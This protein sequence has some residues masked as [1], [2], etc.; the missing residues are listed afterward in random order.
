MNIA[1]ILTYTYFVTA[2]IA[3]IFLY[4]E[5]KHPTVRLG[6]YRMRIYHV[7]TLFIVGAI[8]LLANMISGY[9]EILGLILLI[10]AFATP[11]FLFIHR[12]KIKISALAGLKIAFVADLQLGMSLKKTKWSQ[13]IVD[14]ITAENPDLVLLGGDLIDNEGTDEN[15]SA[16]MAPFGQL[17]GR[18]PIYYVMGNHEY[19]AGRPGVMMFE[20]RAPVLADQMAKLK[21]PLLKNKLE[22]LKLPNRDICIF[23][24]DD[25]WGGQ[26][27]FDEL[28]NWDK[29]TPLIF[30][31]HNPDGVLHWPT[32][33]KK[34]DLVL[35]GHTHGG[36]IHL[37]GLGPVVSAEIKMHRNFYR[38]LKYYNNIPIFTTVGAGESAAPIRFGLMPE[39]AILNIK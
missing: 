23:G 4:R 28:K 34:P 37:P 30:L 38:G 1:Q 20:N 2:I 24:L 33:L 39:V 19:G 15:E 10:V 27:N 9:L 12:K 8:F 21:I 36:Q 13:K 32:E 26:I 25:L 18:F 22:R 35:T 31:T 16:F 14:K 5:R 6:H 17:V 29:T 3:F 7:I 11:H